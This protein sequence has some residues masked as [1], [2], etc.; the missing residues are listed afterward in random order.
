MKRFHHDSIKYSLQGIGYMLSTQPNLRI[1]LYAMFLVSVLATFLKVG[2]FDWLVLLVVF[3]LVVIT[4][5]LNTAVE[6]VVDLVT[7]EYR[8]PAKIAKDV[9]AGMVLTSAVFS[10]II[11]T[12]I[13][14][15]K[16]INL[17]K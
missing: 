4:E 9:A 14:L 16:I 1:H 11:G 12:V 8:Q 5:M 13:F 2:I 17:F 6:S 10:V 7:L 15:P 3:F